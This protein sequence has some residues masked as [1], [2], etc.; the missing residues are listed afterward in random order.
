VI[1]EYVKDDI[2]ALRDIHA[3]NGLPEACLPI[4]TVRTE[5]GEEKDDPLFITKAVLEDDGKPAVMA[6]LKITSE[7]FVLVDHRVG[8]PEERWEWLKKISEHLREE[9]WKRG[10]EQITCF[11]P[12][13]IDKSFAKRLKDLGYIRSEWQ[14]Y[15]LNV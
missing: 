11:V 12:P 3:A 14:S 8:T 9:A 5:D 1:R 13:E 4:L 6:F 7:S 10:L 15:T 2:D